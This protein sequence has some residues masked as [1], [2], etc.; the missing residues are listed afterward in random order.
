MYKYVV[1]LIGVS[2]HETIRLK[3]ANL[4]KFGFS[5]DEIFNLFGRS[6]LMLTLSVDKVQRNMTFILGMMKFPAS[7]VLQYPFLLY[8]N[9]EAVLRPR[10]LLARKIQDMGLDL[11]IKGPKM[12][13]ALRM[14]EKRF[15]E[16]FVKC[17]PRDVADELMAFYTSAKGVKRLAEAS[18]KNNITGFPF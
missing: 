10:V 14:T 3:V 2:H 17:H 9:L 11:Q 16:A 13:T 7:V 1:T 5:D 6:P 15:L 12:M 4:E 8:S 18:K